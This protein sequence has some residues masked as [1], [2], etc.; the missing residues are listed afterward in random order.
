L[1]VLLSRRFPAVLRQGRVLT[2]VGFGSALAGLAAWALMA[3][4]PSALTGALAASL[5]GGAIALAF[6]IPEIRLLRRL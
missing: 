2:R 1:L 6:L 4:V 5:A 3:S